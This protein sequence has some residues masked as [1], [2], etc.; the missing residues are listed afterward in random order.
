MSFDDRSLNDC[1][2]Q[3]LI[4]YHTRFFTALQCHWK[5]K[6]C[7]VKPLRFGACLLQWLPYWLTQSWSWKSW[8]WEAR[9]A[10]YLLKR[11]PMKLPE[12]QVRVNTCPQ[13]QGPMTQLAYFKFQ[14]PLSLL[15]GKF[16]VFSIIHPCLLSYKNKMHKTLPPSWIDF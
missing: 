2:E 10:P 5:F 7:C 3:S 14:F 13:V 12:V 9:A 16:V 15:N 8:C 1:M 6:L 11:F 4:P